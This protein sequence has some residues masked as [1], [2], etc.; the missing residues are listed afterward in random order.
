M[1]H[2]ANNDVTEQTFLAGC[3][4]DLECPFHLACI[5]RDCQDPCQFENCGRNAECRVNNHKARCECRPGFKGNPYQECR[6]YECLSDPECDNALACRNEKCVDPCDCAINA[7]CTPLNHKGICECLPGYEGDPYG[8]I[9][10]PSKS[11]T[12][13]VVNQKQSLTFAKI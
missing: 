9:C 1:I 11:P 12:S 2:F 8:R 10:T 6:Q 7:E 4:S 13:N 5:E 3:K